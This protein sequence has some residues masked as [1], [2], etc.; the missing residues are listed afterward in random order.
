[1][2]EASH[3][4][5]ID[6]IVA[7][8][9]ATKGKRG[10]IDTAWGF[11][12]WFS[13]WTLGE[14]DF[15]FGSDDSYRPRTNARLLIIKAEDKEGNRLFSQADERELLNEADSKEVVRVAREI[16][17]KLNEDNAA[18]QDGDAPKA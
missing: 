1:V 18:T 17:A 2:S 14:K 13:P 8:F 16:L 6:K 10:F 12:V 3:N 9:A 7:H 5:T 4:R 15:V 11:P